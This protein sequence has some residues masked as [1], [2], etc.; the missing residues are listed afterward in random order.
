MKKY[1]IASS[2]LF[3]VLVATYF[4]Q[5]EELNNSTYTT[6]SAL[7]KSMQSDAPPTASV[8]SVGTS[9]IPESK[10][11]SKEEA[12]ETAKSITGELGNILSRHAE[13]ASQKSEVT[14]P[15]EKAKELR[16][17]EERVAAS[18]ETRVL[19]ENNE[20]K[21]LYPN[22]NLT[23]QGLSEDEQIAAVDGIIAE[24]PSLFGVNEQTSLTTVE[25][26]CEVDMC[27]SNIERTYK[28]LPAWDQALRV[29]TV[30][31]KVV[32]IQGAFDVNLPNDVP[33]AALDESKLVA[34]IADHFGVEINQITLKE[35]P[36]LGVA[37]SGSI[38]FYSYR[39]IAEV[40]G[41]G[42]Y[43]IDSY[44]NSLAVVK[45]NPLKT[46]VTVNASGTN[47][48]GDIVTFK[49]RQSGQNYILIDDSI[50]LDG[51]LS[52]FRNENGKITPY[53]AAYDGN[54][55]YASSQS[56]DSGWSPSAVS[57]IE[58]YIKTEQFFRTI[59]SVNINKGRD[60]KILV[61][62]PGANAF[63]L[64][65]DGI[66]AFG[67]GDQNTNNLAGSLDVMGHEITH[68][69]TDLDYIKQSGALN[70]S[71]ADYFGVQVDPGNWL[72]GDTA[73]K[74]GALRNM[75]NPT[76]FGQPAHMT[77]Y[78]DLSLSNDKGGVHINSGIPNRAFYL[79]AE[80]L[81]NEGIG[82]SIGAD[83]TS[84]LIYK[85]LKSLPQSN[86]TFEMAYLN[87]L[88]ISDGIYGA[89]SAE[90]I[91]V[92]ASWEAVGIPDESV[93]IVSGT[94]DSAVNS[95]NFYVYLSPQLSTSTYPG[96]DNLYNIYVQGFVSTAPEY[97]SELNIG[98]LNDIY[99]SF[100]RPAIVFYEDQS[101]SLIY[102]DYLGQIRINL[103]DGS[104]CEGEEVIATGDLEISNIE[105]SKDKKYIAISSSNV[106]EI[107]V[108]DLSNG[109]SDIFEITGPVFTEGLEGAP[110]EAVDSL[111]FD[112]TNRKLTFDYL[113]C[114]STPDSLCENGG[115]VKSW[116]I[117]TID[118]ASKLIS[119]PFAS[120]PADI[121]IGFPAFANL[122]DKFLVIDIINNG[123]V[124][125]RSPSIVALFDAENRDLVGL[126][127]TDYRT[128]KIGHYSAPSFSSDDS[129]IVYTIA[130]D[131]G[132]NYTYALDLND[133]AIPSTG[134]NGRFL[135]P[136]LSYLG[137][138][139]PIYV[140]DRKPLLAV[141][142][143][144]YGLG[145]IELGST[146][147]NTLCV[148]NEG[149]FDILINTLTTNLNLE[150][151]GLSYVAQGGNENCGELRLDTSGLAIGELNSTASFIHDGANSPTS[152][153]VTAYIDYD[154]DSDGVLN[155][156]DDDDD[157]DGVKDVD[158]AYPLIALGE[159]TDTDK[160]GRPNDCDVACVAL[161]MAAD[162]DDD[163][164]FILDVNDGFP[165]IGIGDLPDTDKD[166]RP[167]DC[168][169]ACQELGMSSD[170]DDDG[171]GVLDVT[172]A[173]PL[174]SVAGYSDSDSDGQPNDCNADCIASGMS[175][176]AD[177]DND[178]I[179]DTGDAYPT[180]SIGE[181]TDTDKDGRPND[182]DE[183]CQ[184]LGMAADEDDDNDAVLDVDDGYPLIPIGDLTDTDKDGRPNDCDSAC[185]ELGMAAD[186]DDDND[187]VLD[188]NDAFPLISLGEL[189]D[190]DK[191][192][193][194]NECD[195]NCIASGMAAD[196]DDDNDGILDESDGYPLVAIGDLADTDTDGRPN[197]CDEACVALGMA[198]D[199]DD[200]NDGLPDE[201]ELEFGLNALEADADKDS[202]GDGLTNAEEYQSGSNP[203][204]DDVPP[205]LIVPDDINADS[206][207]RL[208]MVDIGL[209]SAEDYLDGEVNV[210]SDSDGVFAAG[211]NI[212]TWSAKDAAG[213]EVKGEQSVYI[214]PMI[215]LEPAVVVRESK[216]ARI[217]YS[218]NGVPRS[219]PVSFDLQTS[220]TASA[221]DFAPVEGSI[222]I[223]S[224][225]SGEIRLET[226]DD[227][228]TEGAE[229]L[230][231]Q[232]IST[233]G[234]A[235]GNQATSV[236]TILEE[237][238][239]PVL[240]LMVLQNE[241]ETL[242]T[243]LGGGEVRIEL[244][245]SDSDGEHAVDW[246]E[247]ENALFT[248]G[249]A[250][251]LN[252]RFDP[253]DVAA[254]NYL[255]KATVVD[256]QIE[257]QTFP[258]ELLIRVLQDAISDADA[259]GIP[260]A[261]DEFEE[262]YIIAQNSGSNAD[263]PLEASVG[264]KLQLGDVALENG[265]QGASITESDI[266]DQD[267]GFNFPLGLIDF[268][269]YMSAPGQVLKLIVPL[270][271]SIPSG[272]TYRKYDVT[273]GW[274]DFDTT[275]LNNFS[276]A[277][278]T[279]GICPGIGSDAYTNGLVVGADCLELA[280]VDG[281]PNDADN[282]TNGIVVDP[283]GI[284][285]VYTPPVT[286]NP[287]ST[288]G[289]GSSSGGGGGC[290]V[291]DESNDAGLMLLL[292]LALLGIMRERM[293]LRFV[294]KK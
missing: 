212:V 291:S 26:S 216:V 253:N 72:I 27:V 127:L 28:N 221:D 64:G 177:D 120:K 158:D 91:A 214:R 183:A 102:K 30:Q 238:V 1:A 75:A 95:G 204:A 274:R 22:L 172:D 167:N 192:G 3:A 68:S 14:L 234:L 153:S 213:N 262:P 76:E 191:D 194:P 39:T 12:R 29:S 217:K 117:G 228:V 277:S 41:V 195:N 49:A 124:D 178:G 19:F 13:L 215:S 107:F 201:F 258:V 273:N 15:E 112:P 165:L 218:L 286:T 136:F 210:T 147:S 197:D 135:I 115:G 38:D 145:D 259:D 126:D 8:N 80:G 188:E 48:S 86:S 236:L 79:L 170:D 31:D 186:P 278:S 230:E 108:L 171:D 6:I 159:L 70:E 264:V 206:T 114:Y 77:N 74:N 199:P 193:R 239:S 34:N 211:Q 67:T 149:S 231:I 11:I 198:A 156:K 268:K 289:S 249:E 143:E 110:A 32:S 247:S 37:R 232:I 128:T 16:A 141:T 235:L 60:A 66:F 139:E 225:I 56:A 138:S 222:L 163:N 113:A 122:S 241:I 270:S 105:L 243:S 251:G 169:S 33:T 208:T 50:P 2:I 134:S 42:I 285:E 267:N 99:S 90:S 254:G 263:R 40:D 36:Q 280:I 144:Q 45:A 293:S 73:I 209:A 185:Q 223:E 101:Y 53:T 190:T 100:T 78:Q 9:R 44:A 46:H 106:G 240:S 150:W 89:D 257:G 224:G 269:A 7:K 83:P 283:S 5:D 173:F 84:E 242:S 85:T 142:S 266:G 23:L 103:C 166:G 51:S 202:D 175:A 17:W 219:Y 275:G 154:T 96:H 189:L 282:S 87:M 137:R 265:G 151:S 21:G 281:G 180:I 121:D 130:F 162:E 200:D 294:P 152:I 182:C 4:M 52:I 131:G 63:S 61:D 111:R 116:N 69:I 179:E 164:D 205:V 237:P 260:D 125:G 292:M 57:A 123:I 187:N 132:E 244:S 246:S 10:P 88:S 220:G 250:N 227:S 148:K 233:N 35:A 58:N 43:R 98:P 196:T 18:G 276:S 93:T 82:N 168:D 229:T 284:A 129:K 288:G 104:T 261:D 248:V 146:G 71:F 203:S 59:L 174:I 155:Y 65:N 118:F 176:D 20:I 255:V 226:L 287:P 94:S 140:T 245:I 24:Q 119:Y 256:N 271:N 207:G 81:T 181:L 279:D 109:E 133:Y 290:T 97:N 160:D 157:N 184:K 62:V 54:E 92:K 272:A 161:G 55:V 252:F 25:S 47:L